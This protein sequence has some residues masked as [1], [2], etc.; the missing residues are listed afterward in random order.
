[1]VGQCVIFFNFLLFSVFQFSSSKLISFRL[2]LY[3]YIEWMQYKYV[4]Y[5]Q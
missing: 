3:E 2:K 1:M 4:S 5:L